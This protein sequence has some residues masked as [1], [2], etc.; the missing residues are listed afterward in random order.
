MVSTITAKVLP[1]LS[2]KRLATTKEDTN[3]VRK[4]VV[5]AGAR[6]DGDPKSSCFCLLAS[7]FL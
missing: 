6:G 4:P 5:L 1:Q 2:N 3:D 7:L